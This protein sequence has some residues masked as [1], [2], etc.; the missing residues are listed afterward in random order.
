VL[1]EGGADLEDVRQRGVPIGLCS[2]L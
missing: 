1:A 2:P